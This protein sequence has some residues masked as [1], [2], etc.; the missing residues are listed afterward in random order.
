MGGGEL[1]HMEGGGAIMNYVGG[2]GTLISCGRG[3]GE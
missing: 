2:V 3:H 1:M